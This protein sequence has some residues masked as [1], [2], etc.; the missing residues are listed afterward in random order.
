MLNPIDIAWTEAIG[1]WAPPPR[2]RLS[3]WADKYA[4]LS[5]ESSH[6]TGKW[7]SFP[8]QVGMMDA[9][10]D[11]MVERITVMKSARV[12]YS[13]MLNHALGYHIHQDPCPMI[14]V[15]P[16]IDDAEGYSKDEI[17]PMLRD[18]PCLQGVVATVKSRDSDNTILKKK[19]AGGVLNLIGA[20]SPRGFRRISA[21]VVLFDEVDGYPPTA[22]QEGDQIA[23]GIRRTDFFW[24]RKI[25][26]GSTPTVK[27]ISR[28]EA[29]FNESDQRHY[30]VPCPHCEHFQTLE[31]GNLKW[32]EGEPDKA[33]FKCVECGELI[34]HSKKRWMV[35]RGEWRP[36]AGFSGHAGFFIWAAYSYSPNA[37]WGNLA[38]EFLAAKKQAD[39]LRT[40]KNTILGQTWEEAGDQPEWEV[41]IQRGEPYEMGTVPEKAL[42][43]TAGVDTQDNRLAV[44][45]KAW[46][47]GEESWLIFHTELWGDPAQPEVWAELDKILNAGYRHESGQA[48]QILSMGVDSQGHRTQAVYNYC[49]QRQPRAFALQGASRPGRPVIGIKPTLQDI[50][51]GGERIK[52]GVQ[53]WTVGTDT[54]KEIVYSRMRQAGSGAGVMHFPEGLPDEYFKQLTAEKLITRYV[55]GF[56]RREWHRTRANEALDIEVYAYAAAIKAGMNRPGFWDAVEQSLTQREHQQRPKPRRRIISRGING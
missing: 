20:N 6:E 41:L 35:E 46:G 43:I 36:Q 13:K 21:R 11:P 48:L 14:V 45:V 5:P 54:A 29:S 15:Q 38:A 10:T 44:V 50:D 28:V 8:Y 34:P 33:K 56:P 7:R 53:L 31:F 2:M 16:T 22:G 17:A 12:G 30:F 55:K 9:F 4:Y 27:D 18:T 47:R 24:N 42:L 39:T 49:R 26:I 1:F 40:Y 23:L 51:F 19:F 52:G 37:T 3:E 32:P 25:V